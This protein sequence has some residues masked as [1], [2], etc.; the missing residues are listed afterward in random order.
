MSSRA[1]WFNT[2]RSTM[3]LWSCFSPCPLSSASIWS[4]RRSL[5]ILT[6]LTS[7]ASIRLWTSNQKV[8]DQ[9]KLQQRNRGGRKLYSTNQAPTS[10]SCLRNAWERPRS[11]WPSDWIRQR[12]FFWRC[13]PGRRHTNKS[14]SS[15][16]TIYSS[17]CRRAITGMISPSSKKCSGGPFTSLKQINW[18]QKV[19]L[20]PNQSAT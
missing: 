8:R 5:R 17:R 12:A 14:P 2:W 6:C 18:S 10:W 3:T 13:T 15:T 4:Q 19:A 11:H 1:L 16:R 7:W 9:T 20:I